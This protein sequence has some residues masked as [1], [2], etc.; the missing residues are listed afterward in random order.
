MSGIEILD[1]TYQRPR[2]T[3]PEFGGNEDG[4]DGLTNHGPM[5]AEVIVRRN[6][7]LDVH[8]WIDAYL[9]RLVQLPPPSDPVTGHDW[10]VALGNAKRIADGTEY[11]TRQV[12][13]S[14]GKTCWRRRGRG[15]CL[16][17]SQVRRAA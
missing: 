12:G 1:E 9:P 6:M 17:S 10:K 7:E 15:C 11:F 5:A 2:R 4:N 16:A 8:R 14:P 13:E 3:G